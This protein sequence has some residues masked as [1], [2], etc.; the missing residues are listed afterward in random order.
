[1]MPNPPQETA[2]SYQPLRSVLYMPAANPRA[3]AKAPT[4]PCDAVILD[5]EDSVA[6]DAK[7]TARDAACAAVTTAAWTG[8]YVTVRVNALG[9]TWH[10]DD[11]AAVC[12]AGPDAVVVP[13]IDHVDQ[14]RQLA[15]YVAAAAPAHTKLWAMI[16]TP[17]GVAQAQEI[18]ACHD[19]LGALVV[20]TNDLVKELRATPTP[21][22]TEL[23][24]ALQT[25]LLAARAAGIAALDG[26]FNTITDAD[27][28]VAE[29]TQGAQW[30]FD[31]KTL[32]HPKQV[33]P[34]NTAFSPSAEE[35][36][37]AQEV[38]AAWAGRDGQGVATVAGRMIE[39]LH[40][41]AAQRVLAIAEV[42]AQR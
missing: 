10:T 13:K 32:V 20:G 6:P 39:Q 34:A 37:T 42:I 35:I 1:M 8:Q 4:L 16:E 19:R 25:V 26:V 31:G 15:D 36:A 30:G 40:V 9:T 22:R 12:A 24:V 11:L 17:N 38:V 14:A 41:A 18:A 7:T 29:A 28:F 27:G 2:T 3:L 33:E 23:L 5:L 21:D